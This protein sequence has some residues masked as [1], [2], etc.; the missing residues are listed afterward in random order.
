MH[1]AGVKLSP[2]AVQAVQSSGMQLPSGQLIAD[3]RASYAED[4]AR[5]QEREEKA[6]R[7]RE[8]AEARRRMAAAGRLSGGRRWGAG[9]TRAAASRR[10][11]G[12]A[13]SAQELS[14][15]AVGGNGSSSSDASASEVAGRDRGAADDAGLR[16][17]RSPAQAGARTLTVSELRRIAE[18][19]G[20]D[21]Q[22][23]LDDA[24]AKGVEIAD[25]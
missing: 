12:S 17:A 7:A 5:E 9:L 25:E 23:L 10:P 4:A 18:R 13:E 2:D 8:Q 15:G 1:A 22:V 21:L 11:G 20:L 3:I 6:R 14:G 16:S 19:K 24:R